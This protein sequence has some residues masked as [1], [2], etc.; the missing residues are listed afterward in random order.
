MDP[1]NQDIIRALMAANPDQMGGV[2]SGQVEDNMFAV[3]GLPLDRGGAP[4]PEP[5]PDPAP[6]PQIPSSG[7]SEISQS[8]GGVPPD[9][10]ADLPW[11]QAEANAASMADGSLSY[12]PGTG[13]YPPTATELLQE[14]KF[15]DFGP[16]YGASDEGHG[17]NPMS[18]DYYL[19]GMEGGPQPGQLDFSQ[20]SGIPTN[21]EDFK[22][23]SSTGGG[24]YTIAESRGA[25]LPM[26]YQSG[27]MSP[28]TNNFR[29]LG[30]GARPGMIVRNGHIINLRDTNGMYGPFGAP[31]MGWNPPH[32]N[33][34]AGV[35]LPV[36]YSPSPVS[37]AISGWPGQT[38][39][40][41]WHSGSMIGGS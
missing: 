34:G 31:S 36:A 27:S 14:P 29:L 18:P 26:R 20:G 9:P 41:S 38:E 13:Y 25:D 32:W 37:W 1:T 8:R 17:D 16:P 23:N 40:Y 15:F 39:P 28:S 35:G 5:P 6:I 19:P 21:W 11:T 7:P 4:P 30:P 3:P 12:A 2:G 33:S 10:W 22:G 24:F